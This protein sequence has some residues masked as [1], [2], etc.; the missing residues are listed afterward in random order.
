MIDNRITV[1]VPTSPIPSHPDTRI[2]DK[3]LASIRYHL[4]TARIIILAD[5]VRS[6]VLHRKATYEEFLFNIQQ[7]ACHGD[8]GRT[9]VCLFKEHYHQ[10]GM[11]AQILSWIET[12]LVYF[13]EHDVYL[14]TDTNPRDDENNGITH[15][16]DTIICWDDIADL[17]Q[18][19]G[20]NF[21]RFYLWEKIWH[22]HQHLMC[23]Q[24]LQG[25]SKFIQTRQWSGW[26]H[27]ASTTFY[28][29]ILADRYYQGGKRRMLELML[30][31]K[32]EQALWSEYRT[33]IYYPEPNARRF[34][35]MNGRFD[36]V[37]GKRDLADGDMSWH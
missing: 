34:F 2:V 21:V 7:K 22:E 28:K 37:T 8:Y 24:M 15:R 9:E 6:E 25:S 26:P 32:V 12:P 29:E 35:H 31:G 27:V 5:G 19:G 4:P 36:E 20:A 18:S 17:I 33:T 11:L 16:E 10:A 13:N 1:L 3:V 23:G 30:Y 14:V